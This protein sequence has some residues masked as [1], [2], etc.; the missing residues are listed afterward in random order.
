LPRIQS[1]LQ[2]C[3]RNTMLY[4]PVTPTPRYRRSSRTLAGSRSCLIR[5]P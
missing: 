2:S 1:W 3:A 4:F 5:R